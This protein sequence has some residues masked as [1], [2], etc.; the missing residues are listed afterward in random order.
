[1][2]IIY[3]SD[4]IQKAVNDLALSPANDKIPSETLDK[5]QLIYGL[6][7]EYSNFTINGAST[8]SGALNIPMP[9]IDAQRQEIFITT[10]IV[11]I[12]KDATCDA[13]TG[14]FI[15]SGT[16]ADGIARNMLNIEAIT[17]TA[18]QETIPLA[19]TYPLKM[20][21]NVNM[22]LS[23][24]FTVGSCVRAVSIYGFIKSSN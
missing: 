17:T 22:S 16:A 6:N 19:L 20:K 5:I 4:V 1:M 18:L 12:A 14:P 15:L 8:T 7:S 24:T 13:A 3:K 9:T 23:G 10:I 21:P 11:S 2:A